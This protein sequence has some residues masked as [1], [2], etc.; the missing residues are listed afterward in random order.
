[1]KHNKRNRLGTETKV[2]AKRNTGQSRD[3]S[4]EAI[5]EYSLCAE[6]D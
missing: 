5:K 4:E 2:Y 3:L 1:M 6:F